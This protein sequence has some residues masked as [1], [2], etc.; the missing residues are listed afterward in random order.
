MYSKGNQKQFEFFAQ[1]FKSTA[2][3]EKNKQPSVAKESYLSLQKIIFNSICFIFIS[4][5]VFSLGIKRG[6]AIALRE[7]VSKSDVRQKLETQAPLP[8]QESTDFIPAKKTPVKIEKKEAEQEKLDFKYTIQV[9]TYRGTGY[10]EKELNNLRK[11]GYDAFTV[12][13]GNFVQICVG[14]F[15]NKTNAKVSLNQL[16]KSYQD[17]FIRRI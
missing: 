13:V 5:F 1:I 11:K 10:A 14:K 16:K 3:K 7:I 8:K 6:K 12:R 2:E 17:C 4:T 9:A 15:L